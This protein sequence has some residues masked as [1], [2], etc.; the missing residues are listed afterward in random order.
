MSDNNLSWLL[1]CPSSDG[2]FK[3]HLKMASVD[4]LE[5]ALLKL[6]DFHNKTKIK[7]IKSEL[8]RR[9]KNGKL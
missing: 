8:N 7:T 5:T 1:S 6:P 2:N 9:I 4:E 3:I